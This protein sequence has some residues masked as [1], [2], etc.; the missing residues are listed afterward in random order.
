MITRAEYQLLKRA[1]DDAEV[2][3]GEQIGNP[4]PKPLA[5]FDARIR[6]TRKVLAKVKPGRRSSG[7]T[8]HPA[9]RAAERA[10]SRP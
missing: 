9:M 6:A 2:W 8:S 4:D 3:R 7:R 5:E 10:L 1:V